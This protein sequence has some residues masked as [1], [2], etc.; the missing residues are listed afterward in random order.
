MIHNDDWAIKSRVKSEQFLGPVDHAMSRG[1]HIYFLTKNNNY[2]KN[3][4]I[5]HNHHHDPPRHYLLYLAGSKLAWRAKR[6]HII[7]N[8]WY[9]GCICNI[10]NMC[11]LCLMFVD[12]RYVCV[13]IGCY[14]L[15]LCMWHINDITKPACHLNSFFK[16]YQYG[17][18][19]LCVCV[20]AR[21][22]V[23]VCMCVHMCMCVAGGCACMCAYY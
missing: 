13:Y 15:V 19:W 8:N 12:D 23:C 3:I 7:H 4:F 14:W 18:N 6:V 21:A 1:G 17:I 9:Y 2:S 22:R 20:R 11:N 16:I 10:C 5:Y